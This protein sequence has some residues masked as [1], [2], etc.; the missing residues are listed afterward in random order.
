RTQR[1]CEKNKPDGLEF[2]WVDTCCINGSSTGSDK[3]LRS[4]FRWC[5]NSSICIVHLGRRQLPSVIRKKM[6]VGRGS[7]GTLYTLPRGP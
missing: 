4:M 6:N 1:F 2:A 3:L 7:S 5:H